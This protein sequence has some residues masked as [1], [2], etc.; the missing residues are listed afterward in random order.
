MVS[1]SYFFALQSIPPVIPQIMGE[2]DLAYGEA[3]LL[4]STV[5]VTGAALSLLGWP[6]IARWGIKKTTTAC[7]VVC[8]AGTIIVFSGGSYIQLILGRA[9]LGVGGGL[10][11]VSSF[12]IVA[13]WFQG[14]DTGRAMG[15]KAI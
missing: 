6:M 2:L 7:L 8:V 1:F 15:F 3:G 5:A 4:M 12:A 9:V 13:L 11:T 10:V 14:R